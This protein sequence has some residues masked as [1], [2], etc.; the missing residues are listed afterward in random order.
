[1]INIR[2][3]DG[4]KNAI[5]VITPDGAKIFQCISPST[6]VYAHQIKRIT[7]NNMFNQQTEWIEKFEMSIKF[8]Q[9]K[10]K[11]GPAPKP[12][13]KLQQQKSLVDTKS[14]T[15]D[16]SPDSQ[17]VKINWGPDWLCMAPEEILAMIAQRHFEDALA[18]ITKCEEYF[19]RDATFHN[20]V[21]I[22]DKV[23]LKVDFVGPYCFMTIS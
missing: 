4:V 22:I 11:K 2:D 13:T 6:K 16:L 17:S 15:S 8:N 12:P 9:L 23:T 3:L 1:M 7:L 20:S 19:A 14:I 5:N 21:E 18:T 10:P